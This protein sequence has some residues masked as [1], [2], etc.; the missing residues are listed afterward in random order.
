MRTID[1]RT[2]IPILPTRAQRKL[3]P[4]HDWVFVQPEAEMAQTPTGIWTPT[5]EEGGKQSPEAVVRAVGPECPS[6]IL[7]G[8][9]VRFVGIAHDFVCDGET[10]YLVRDAMP[11]P[12]DIRQDAHGLPTGTAYITCIIR[13]DRELD[14]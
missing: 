8:D 3:A 2:A 12:G 9:R 13:T 7:V 11:A 1:A 5:V 10:Y 4:C 14:S 6:G